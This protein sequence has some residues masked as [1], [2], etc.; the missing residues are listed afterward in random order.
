MGLSCMQRALQVMHLRTE[1]AAELWDLLVCYAV[2]NYIMTAD[3]FHAED[4]CG[5]GLVTNHSYTVITA[6]NAV[7]VESD[8]SNTVHRLVC[9]RNPWSNSSITWQGDFG[10]NSKKWNDCLKRQ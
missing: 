8:G 5:V 2:K 6:I 3:C 7:D 1:P 4:V 10:V 9:L